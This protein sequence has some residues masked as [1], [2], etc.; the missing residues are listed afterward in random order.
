MSVSTR[1]EASRTKRTF[2]KP[3]LNQ[4]CDEMSNGMKRG[5]NSTTQGTGEDTT[6]ARMR[7][8]PRQPPKLP[9]GR[10]EFLQ[11]NSGSNNTKR[12]KRNCDDNLAGMNPQ[13][14]MKTMAGARS[15]LNPETR[16]EIQEGIAYLEF[17]K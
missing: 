14:A 15:S 6:G 17:L 5:V 9:Q 4:L 1:Q 12:E 13:E 16:E 11:Y 2:E 10:T 7:E 8:P 3:R